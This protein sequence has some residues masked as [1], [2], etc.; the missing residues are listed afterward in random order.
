[1]SLQKYFSSPKEWLEVLIAFIACFIVLVVPYAYIS[2]NYFHISW[3]RI[4]IFSILVFIGIPA[5]HYIAYKN[6]SK[7]VLNEINIVEIDQRDELHKLIKNQSPFEH[8]I[9]GA[10]TTYKNR[11]IEIAKKAYLK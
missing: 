8:L 10:S 1:M 2:T 7:S 4:T 3:V 6:Q 9:I 5:I 11:R